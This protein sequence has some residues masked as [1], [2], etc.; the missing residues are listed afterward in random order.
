MRLPKNT[1]LTAQK[2]TVQYS[3]IKKKSIKIQ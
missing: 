2:A 3:L 1:N